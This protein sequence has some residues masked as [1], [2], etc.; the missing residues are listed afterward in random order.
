MAENSRPK[1]QSRFFRSVSHFS[2]LAGHIRVTVRPCGGME[3]DAQA[4][5]SDLPLPLVGH[6]SLGK[7][8]KLPKPQV[9]RLRHGD[10]DVTL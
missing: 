8:Y 5:K 4:L 7:L 9:P 3:G 1:V 2:S 6:V 10:D